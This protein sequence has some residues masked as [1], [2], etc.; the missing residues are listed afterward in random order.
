M[1]T[2]KNIWVVI[3]SNKVMV[4][5]DMQLV[6]NEIMLRTTPTCD[7]TL[8]PTLDEASIFVFQKYNLYFYS[9]NHSL[10]DRAM[11]LPPSGTFNL[12]SEEKNI[13]QNTNGSMLENNQQAVMAIPSSLPVCNNYNVAGVWA[14][15]CTKGFGTIVDLSNLMYTMIQFVDC[16]PSAYWHPIYEQ[17]E[18]HARTNYI[19]R[20]YQRYN[21]QQESPTLPPNTVP[22]DR[23]YIDQRYDA[24]EEN[25]KDSPIL[26]KL[27]SAGLLNRDY[28]W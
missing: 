21:A 14:F 19:E 6:F 23:I 2:E 9:F 5:W 16:Y 25:R 1:A 7:I 22:L 10:N 26:Q 12:C 27:F 18:Y 11:S 17:A 3:K 13:P 28:E 8:L 20:F 15:S 4:E 24:R